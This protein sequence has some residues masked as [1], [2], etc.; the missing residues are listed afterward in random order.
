MQLV[1]LQQSAKKVTDLASGGT[2]RATFE[3]LRGMPGK[4]SYVGGILIELSASL[5]QT[6][7]TD[8]ISI[9][10]QQDFLASLTYQDAMGSVCDALTGRQLMNLCEAMGILTVDKLALTH[11]ATLSGTDAVSFS[12]SFVLP[13]CPGLFTTSNGDKDDFIGCR[14]LNEVEKAGNLTATVVADGTDPMTG[15]WGLT[16]GTTWTLQITP[17]MVYS[18]ELLITHR[19]KIGAVGKAAGDTDFTLP[20]DGLKTVH[21]LKVTAQD[22]SAFAEPTDM[23]ADVDGVGVLK[24]VEGDTLHTALG[25]L[26]EE[27]ANKQMDD[28]QLIFAAIQNGFDAKVAGEV[29]KVTNAHK[30]D[31]AAAFYSYCYTRAPFGN[32]LESDLIKQGV[33]PA[34]ARSVRVEYETMESEEGERMRLRTSA[35]ATVD[36]LPDQNPDRA[37]QRRLL[38]VDGA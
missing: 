6:S 3:G 14:P 18:D 28:G 36:A 11:G 29:I 1:A 38:F 19:T 22:Y 9:A 25:W 5:T 8:T 27:P 17:V 33:K 13:F 35:G 32:E 4:Y 20:G 16:S 23:I 34:V 15:N 12:T 21:A 31:A 2:E 26:G 30:A 10:A 37:V 7:G 24:L